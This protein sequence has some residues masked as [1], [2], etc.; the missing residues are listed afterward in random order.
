VTLPAWAPLRGDVPIRTAMEQLQVGYLHA[1]AAAAGCSLSSPTPDRGIDWHIDHASPQHTVDSEVTIKVALKSTH[2]IK[3]RPPA[4]QF[5]FTLDN[6]HLEKLSGVAPTI[7]RLMIVMVVPAS[8]QHW[9][10]STGNYLQLRHCA[11]W[12]NLA[13]HA[14]TGQSKTNVHIQTSHVFDDLAL[15]EIMRTVGQGGVPQ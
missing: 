9:V 4:P 6:D 8:M 3:P 7:H 1:I 13:G 5:S 14:I 12:V 15:C 10:L 2:Q 11:Y